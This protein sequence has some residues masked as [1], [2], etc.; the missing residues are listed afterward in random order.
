MPNEL[1]EYI[2]LKAESGEILEPDDFFDTEHTPMITPSEI[3]EFVYC[4]R[5]LYFMNTLNIPQHEELRYKVIKGRQIHRQREKNNPN[6]LRKKIDCI[7]KD[8][9][10]YLASKKIG[11]RG[12]VDEVLHLR[13]GTLAPMDYKFTFYT[14]FTFKTHR[15][16]SNLYALLIQDVYKKPVKKGFICYIRNGNSVKELEYTSNDFEKTLKIVETIKDILYKGYY[17]RK[18]KYPMRCVDCTYRNICDK[19]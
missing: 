2:D 10:V 11:V 5:F 6:Y 16:Q 4:P 14:E 8:T 1:E 9:S 18:T 15:I 17:P 12:I 3:I 13:D 19:T 7:R